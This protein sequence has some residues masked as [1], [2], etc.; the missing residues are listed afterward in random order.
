MVTVSMKSIYIYIYIYICMYIGIHEIVSLIN[1]RKKIFGHIISIDS[2]RKI[3]PALHAILLDWLL[4]SW[5]P[6]PRPNPHPFNAVSSMI[7][8]SSCSAI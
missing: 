3:A 4:S 7:D 2:V 8:V 5:L 6:S 1:I